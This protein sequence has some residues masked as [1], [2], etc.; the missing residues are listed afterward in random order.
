MNAIPDSGFDQ[1]QKKTT[2]FRQLLDS[3]ALEFLLE[4]HNGITAKIGEE[5]GF[6]GLWAG[7]L[8]MSAQYGVRDS[9]EASWTQ[10]LEMLEFMADATSVPILLDGDTGYGNFNNVRRLV[11][12]LEQRGIAAVCIEDKLYPKTNSFIDGNQQQLAEIDEFCSRIKAGKDAQTD[13]EFAIITRVEAFIA[14]WGL[15]E[16]LKRAEAY[17]AA[18]ADGI[19]IHSALNTP[20]EVL[21]FKQEWA[22]RSPVLIVPTKY[23][24]T[25]T[26]VLSEAG[27]SI[28]IWANHMLRAAITTM[29]EC[30]ETLAR[31]QN[32]CSIED[33]VASVKE[34]FRLQGASEL[35]AAE[36]RY[37][38]KD[39]PAQA[40][41]LAASRGAALGTLTDKRPKT[42]VEVR[43]QPL[44]GHIVTAYNASGIK[45]ITVVRGYR[46][47][48]VN[49]PALKYVDNPD[50]ADTSELLS[51]DCALKAAG[52][53]DARGD[54]YVSFGDVIFKRYILDGLAELAADFVIAVDTDWSESVNRGR[55]ADYVRCSESYSRHTFYREVTLVAAGE[56]LGDDEIHGEWMGVLRVSASGLAF[57][58]ALVDELAAQP[59]NRCGKLHQVLD[60]LV[61]RGQTVRVV[62]TTGHWLD[63]DSLDDVLAA[64]SFA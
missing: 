40:I 53:G 31:E 15:G 9:N 30:A 52:R 45:D 22:D 57:F 64:G 17:H 48:T 59:E 11:R 44:L 61:R 14:G 18:G 35:Q 26:E 7:G 58:T 5:A 6:K 21:A 55:A 19:L 25:P 54:L 8:C 47:A 56:K 38:P 13:D 33:Q 60:E 28:A 3:G 32:L 16:A 41:I 1:P 34:I 29:Q 12:K 23:Y 63:V 62:Y 37:L 39:T 46:P 24:A 4:A 42:M 36:E 50:F 20:A 43:G 2:R 51:L 27:F 49:L 10:I